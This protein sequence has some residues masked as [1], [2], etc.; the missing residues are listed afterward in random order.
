M[1]GA[2]ALVTGNLASAE[3]AV[4]E[5]LVRAWERTQRGE[6]IERLDAWVA[7]VAL[8]L[9]RSAVRRRL[10]E[11]RAGR[12]A[13]QPVT[14]DPGEQDRVDVQRALSELPRRQREAAV[15]R[16]FAG[17]NTREIAEV[18]G[19]SE[20][21]V[22]SQLAKARRHLAESLALSEEPDRETNHADA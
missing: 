16:Y 12:R 17:M 18:M 4:Q 15:L 11:L 14:A 13:A 6:R 22:K 8:N 1:V 5:A 9:S 20:G 7:T 10:T 2:V 21:T 19:T 3:D